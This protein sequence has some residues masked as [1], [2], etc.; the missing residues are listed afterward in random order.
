MINLHRISLFTGVGGVLISLLSFSPT[1]LAGSGGMAGSAAFQVDTVVTGV[2]V[3]AAV[4]ENGASAWSFN[5]STN[6]SEVNSAGSL[7]SGGS[8]TIGGAADQFNASGVGQVV[9]STNS[10]EV[11]SNT[12]SNNADLELGTGS[13]NIIVD[14]PPVN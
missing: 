1:A 9:D 8:I 13:N 2:G 7:G 12:L 6:G 4:G 11:N 3:S 5:D 14:S 10:A